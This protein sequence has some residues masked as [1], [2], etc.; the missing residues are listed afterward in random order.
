[1]ALSKRYR[2]PLRFER[3][4]LNEVGL[5][6]QGSFY[7][8]IIAE[9]KQD[10]KI[11]RFAVIISKKI[12]NLAT[13]R[14]KIRRLTSEVLNSLISNIKCSDYLIIPKRAILSASYSQ[15]KEDLVFILHDQLTH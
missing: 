13:D 5:K 9:P 15:I 2:L 10:I 4:R 3:S 12:S 1:M 14:N 8:I 7:T 11:P 6:R